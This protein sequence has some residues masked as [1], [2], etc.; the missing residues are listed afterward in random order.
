MP[1][2]KV[3]PIK[4]EVDEKAAVI[5][6]YCKLDAQVKAFAPT[7]SRHEKLRET[8]LAWHPDLS[9]VQAKTLSGD[10]Y[11]LLIGMAQEQRRI[12]NMRKVFRKLGATVFLDHCTMT[13]KALTAALGEAEAAKYL[14]SGYTGPRKLTPIPREKAA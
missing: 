10:Q 7:K 6:E 11:E 1:A 13:L 4:S 2:P 5:D 9:G 8:I 12:G 3:Q 14:E